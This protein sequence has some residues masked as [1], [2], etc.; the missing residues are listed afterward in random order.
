MHMHIAVLKK[1][2][3]VL[4]ECFLVGGDVKHIAYSHRYS[5]VVASRSKVTKT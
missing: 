1:K 5:Y 3:I 2:T 4:R